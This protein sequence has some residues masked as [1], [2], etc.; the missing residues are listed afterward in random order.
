MNGKQKFYILLGSFQIVLI[1]LVIFTTNGI[2]TF[3]A[4]QTTDPLAYFDTSTTIAL[5]LA[6]AISVSSAVLGSAWAIRTVGTAAIASLSE[7]EEAFFKAFLVVALCEALAVY[8]LI[9]AILLW[10]KIP[11]PPV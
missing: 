7:R 4:A 2:I 8:G 5:A 10:T 11:Q 6:T 1:F 3:V 9:V